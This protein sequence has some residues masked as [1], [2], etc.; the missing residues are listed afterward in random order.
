MHETN[1]QWSS[2]WKIACDRLQSLEEQRLNKTKAV[3]W[4]YANIISQTC[5]TDDESCEKLRLTL[6][7]CDVETEIQRFIVQNQ[8]SHATPLAGESHEPLR[9]L[10][11]VERV[12]PSSFGSEQAKLSK[13]AAS[14][15]RPNNE[16]WQDQRSGLCNPV[17]NESPRATINQHPLDGITQLCRSDSSATFN[18]VSNSVTGS[19]MTASSVYSSVHGSHKHTPH[20]SLSNSTNK[21]GTATNNTIRQP[22]RRKSFIERVDFSWPAR[23][24]PGP[25][26]SDT[27]KPLKAQR[28][29]GSMFDALRPARSRSRAGTRA[30]VFEQDADMPLATDPRAMNVL[31]IGHNMLP[32][33]SPADVRISE[34]PVSPDD[35]IADA[36]RSLKLRPHANSTTV[37][38]TTSLG[39]S[40]DREGRTAPAGTKLHL[41]H[42]RIPSRSEPS[43]PV[44][45]AEFDYP[46]RQ[47]PN[48]YT[49]ANARTAGLG[50]PPPAHSAEEMRQTSDRFSQRNTSILGGRS[51][52]HDFQHSSHRPASIVPEED[53]QYSNRA[54]SRASSP[55]LYSNYSQ[56]SAPGDLR[57]SPS[58]NPQVNAHRPSSRTSSV[59]PQ[60]SMSQ[61]TIGRASSAFASS[62]KQD[63]RYRSPSPRVDADFGLDTYR[64]GTA[65]RRGT[66]SPSIEMGRPVSPRPQLVDS[67]S[68][69]RSRQSMVS[70]HSASSNFASE[71]RGQSRS[72]EKSR[73]PSTTYGDSRYDPTRGREPNH[74]SADLT[75][76]P[77]NRTRS[78]SFASSRAKLTRDGREI[79]AFVI[80]LYDYQATIPEEIGF[81]QGDT[82]AI[83]EMRQDGWWVGEVTNLRSPRLGLVPSNFFKRI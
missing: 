82:L 61:H 18:S 37:Q 50:A 33:A 83:V 75:Y 45:G 80:A 48:T 2:S 77:L 68:R 79:I 65:S 60:S 5:V 74:T 22:G 40:Y 58:P 59:R 69:S 32:V 78:K 16:N 72:R 23:R 29:G 55:Q 66:K 38:N 10:D 81:C 31:N 70:V 26:K 14:G 13:I 19:T 63:P 34:V 42:T 30:E 17:L 4:S 12:H 25:G 28:T 56:H 67:N 41:G 44:S 9:T 53:G 7:S 47:N 36:L 49:S 20:M 52:T 54:R 6:E 71:A 39:K 64:D 76:R 51:S 46:P 15:D 1:E 11:K 57:R 21:A 3:L 27:A 43:S 73:S 24:S 8:S 35:P 62:A